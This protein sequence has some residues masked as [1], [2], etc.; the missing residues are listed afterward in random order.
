MM[1]SHQLQEVILLARGNL[2]LPARCREG[3][4]VGD[5]LGKQ[6]SFAA[7]AVVLLFAGS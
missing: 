6:S 1:T 5:V 7:A 3:S 2:E 4:A